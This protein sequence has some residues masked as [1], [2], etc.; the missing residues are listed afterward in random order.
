MQGNSFEEKTSNI[1][2]WFIHGEVREKPI[3]NPSSKSKRKRG[4]MTPTILS[5]ESTQE[6]LPSIGCRIRMC[7]GYDDKGKMSATIITPKEDV[8][9]QFWYPKR[10][11]VINEY[12]YIKDYYSWSDKVE[13]ESDYAINTTSSKI[14]DRRTPQKKS[15][16][17]KTHSSKFSDKMYSSDSSDMMFDPTHDYKSTQHTKDSKPTNTISSSSRISSCLLYTSD[18]AD[19]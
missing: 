2:D 7:V 6:D 19:E 18:A 13:K 1:I 14:Y 5:V 17:K 15:E 11:R 3:K 9:H 16:R 4:K 10:N 12:K 8:D